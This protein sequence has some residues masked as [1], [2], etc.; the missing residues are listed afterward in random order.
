ME[1]DEELRNRVV[2]ASVVTILAMIF[3]PMLLNDPKED[4]SQTELLTI[5]EKPTDYPSL[6]AILLPDDIN[7][8]IGNVST[9]V[10]INESQ[11]LPIVLKEALPITHPPKEQLVPVLDVTTNTSLQA[12][13]WFIQVASFNREENAVV[14]R[15]TLRKQGF[16]ANVAPALLNGRTVYRLRVGPELSKQRAKTIKTKLNQ[17]NNVKSIIL[18]D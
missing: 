1:I 12:K 14:F 2:G 10:K 6:T 4:I 3:L 17:L 18:S 11:P 15:D 9:T 5:P 13:R 16:S 7:D 8:V